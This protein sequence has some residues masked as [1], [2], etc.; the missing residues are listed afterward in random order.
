MRGLRAASILLA[1]ATSRAEGQRACE[2]LPAPLA[3]VVE[4]GW[5]AYRANEMAR[6]DSLF[7]AV[8]ARCP[9]NVAAAN[10]RG[11]VLL[12]GS[13]AAGAAR[14]LDAVL[15]RRPRDQAGNPRRDGRAGK[16]GRAARRAP[17]LRR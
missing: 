3:R 4:A 7:A 8:L 5:T 16:A 1:I 11:Y 2:P 15:A 14:A 9:R 6:G 13:D 17:Q 12:R 10:G